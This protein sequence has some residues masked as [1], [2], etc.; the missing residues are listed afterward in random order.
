MSPIFGLQTPQAITTYSASMVPPEVSTLRM[1][2]SLTPRPVTSTLGTTVRAPFARAFSRMIVPA[3]SESTTPTEG[4]QKAPMIWSGSRK[5]TF[6]TTKSGS[7]SSASMPHA[8]ALDIRRR[9]SSIRSSVRATSKPPDSVK[10]PISLYWRTESS[11][12]SVISRV[13]STGKMK[14]E[15]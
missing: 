13:W 12:R 15:A 8:L 3:R 10:T 5:G 9:S 2:P 6:S 7:T 14:L 1:R 4:V 11:V